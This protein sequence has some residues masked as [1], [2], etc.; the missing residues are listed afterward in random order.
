MHVCTELIFEGLEAL[1][2]FFH[3]AG[4]ML[5]ALHVR[6]RFGRIALLHRWRR[7]YCV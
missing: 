7:Y 6:A 4:A 1:Q 2:T 5:E 3:F